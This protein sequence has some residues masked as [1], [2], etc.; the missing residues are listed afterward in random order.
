[1]KIDSNHQ[2][3]PV[4]REFGFDRGTPIDRYYIESFLKL[5]SHDIKGRVLEISDSYYTRNF[6]GDQVIKSD[7]LHVNAD[8]QN[9][10]IVGDIETCKVLPT[11]VFDCI[12]LTQVLNV[13]YDT[14]SAIRHLNNALKPGG[15][16]LASV[17]GISQISRYDMDRWGDYWRFTTLSANRLFVEVFPSTCVTVKA[18]GNVLTSSAFL[19]GLAIEEL[20]QNE[21]NYHDPDYE[22]LIGIRAIKP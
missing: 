3:K 20:S 10:T 15:I 18:Y 12:L 14:K 13:I 1:M 22:L 5:F 8:E 6:G 4:S 16:L 2:L 17:P 21:L 19:Y 7:I 9:A 11:G